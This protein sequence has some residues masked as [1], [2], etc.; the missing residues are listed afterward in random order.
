MAKQQQMS[1]IGISAENCDWY[2]IWGS[3]NILY[4][5]TVTV[6]DDGQAI[7]LFAK[8][9]STSVLP[10]GVRYGYAPWPVV[11]Y[12]NEFGFPMVPFNISR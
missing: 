11:N 3:D 8:A 5:A 6:V 12:Y 7:I 2:G 1:D 4:N 9:A 10:V